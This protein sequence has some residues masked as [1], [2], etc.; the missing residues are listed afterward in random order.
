[1]SLVDL[2]RKKKDKIS[3]S[4]KHNLL[5]SEITNIYLVL[6]LTPNTYKCFPKLKKKSLNVYSMVRMLCI[7]LINVTE[8]SSYLI[9]NCI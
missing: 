8:V 7:N 3:S 5:N 4:A 2:I 1:M 6:I 9:L